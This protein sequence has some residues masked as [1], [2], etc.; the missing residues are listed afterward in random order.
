M[1]ELTEPWH[2]YFFR[3]SSSWEVTNILY[4][5]F[6]VCHSLKKKQNEESLLQDW[7]YTLICSLQVCSCC[8][9][10]VK[11]HRQFSF[12]TFNIVYIWVALSYFKLPC[13]CLTLK[14]LWDFTF[15]SSTAHSCVVYAI[16]F[17]L[18]WEQQ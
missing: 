17:S 12:V 2:M 9:C 6:F 15:L 7:F 16:S 8:L 11:R 13:W 1:K 5:T 3:T 14:I 4:L 18:W 10:W